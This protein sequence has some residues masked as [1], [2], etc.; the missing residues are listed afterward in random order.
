MRI[1]SLVIL[2]SCLGLI[3]CTASE[4]KPPVIQDD[5]GI[6]QIAQAAVAA[7]QSL[8]VMAATEQAAL[9]PKT[10]IVN[11]DPSTYAM[12]QVVSIDWAGPIETLLEQIAHMTGYTFKVIGK[13]PAV[14]VLVDVYARNEA[15]G[16]ILR[17]AAYQADKRANVVVYPKS[18]LIELRY[19]PA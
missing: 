5:A 1:K 8:E 13:P 18:K 10:A 9:T 14:P 7:S 4:V 15:V 19:V 12:A 17:N 2:L 3:S 16:D 6:N 11:P